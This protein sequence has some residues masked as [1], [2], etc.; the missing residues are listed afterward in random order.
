VVRGVW[1]GTGILVALIVIVTLHDVL[2]VFFAAAVFAVPLRAG[3]IGISRSLHVPAGVGLAALLGALAL[4]VAAVLWG[5]QAILAGQVTQLAVTLPSATDAVARALREEPWA[6]RLAQM[7]LDPG[8][9]L[10]GAGGLVGAL[11][12]VL[13]G[14]LAGLVDVAILIFA[15]VCFAA[16]PR[17]YVGGFLHLIPPQRRARVEA[18]LGEAGTTIALWLRA[19]AISMIAVGVLSGFGLRALGVPDAIALGVLAGLF[20]FIPNVGPIAAGLPAV[21]LAA[22]LGWQHVAGVGLLFWL[23]HALDDF[24]VIPIAERRIV[25]LPPALTI[26]AQLV[27]GLA[28]GALGIMM[29]APLVAVAI[30][31]MRRLVVEDIVEHDLA[32]GAGSLSLLRHEKAETS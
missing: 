30:V 1:L 3:A 19:R 25:R 21:L 8:V 14:T 23:A 27:L 11:R 10:A 16:E 15:A 20:A 6:S 9:L 32:P 4:A 22:P 5:W 18:V 29:A 28:S 7:H 13:G 17:T 24:F 12:G 2:L 26:A 31:V